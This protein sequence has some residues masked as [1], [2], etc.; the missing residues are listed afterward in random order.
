[1]QT[2]GEKVGWQF[3]E[4]PHVGFVDYVV[5]GRV[6]FDRKASGPN[7]SFLMVCRRH[8]SLCLHL[9]RD[10]DLQVPNPADRRSRFRHPRVEFASPIGFRK[11]AQFRS[12]GA[13]LF[14][15]IPTIFPNLLATPLSR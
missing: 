10:V 4:V 5:R 15:E 2:E 9:R 11:K 3:S 12:A 7:S 13:F 8:P 6:E 1:M 14:P